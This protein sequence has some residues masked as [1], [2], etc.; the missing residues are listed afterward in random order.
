[1]EELLTQREAA[2]M[3]RVS[4]KWM[5]V[6]RREG[7]IGFVR[8]GHRTVLIPKREVERLKGAAA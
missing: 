2:Q 6:A 3:L 7:R 1:M 8:L 5:Q 4:V